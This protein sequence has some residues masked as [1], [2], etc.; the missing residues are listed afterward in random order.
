MS[1][2]EKFANPEDGVPVVDVIKEALDEP[3]ELEEMTQDQFKEI[4]ESK[5]DWKEAC[6]DLAYM[7]DKKPRKVM[8]A[9]KKNIIRERERLSRMLMKIPLSEVDL[10][11][12]IEREIR[13]LCDIEEIITKGGRE[14]RNQMWKNIFTLIGVLVPAFGLQILAMIFGDKLGGKAADK[15]VPTMPKN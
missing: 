8:K 3:A 12:Q 5:Q 11:A 7:E 1:D 9:F 4:V 2:L 15:H 6:Q 13:N 10:R 14:S